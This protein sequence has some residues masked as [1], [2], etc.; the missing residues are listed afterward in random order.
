MPRW[1]EG[2]RRRLIDTSLALFA[3]HGYADASI[4]D[5]ALAAGL[6][7]RTFYRYFTDKE[8]VL[9]GDDDQLLPVLL[10]AIAGGIG[11]VNAERH[12]SAALSRLA[13]VLEPQRETLRI[14]QKIIDSQVSLTGR[15]L[16]KQA[17]W[18]QKVTAALIERGFLPAQADLLAS[19]GFALF[20][21]TLHSW[22]ADDDD[23]SLADRMGEALRHARTVLDVSSS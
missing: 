22:L 16:A 15:E 6:A 13:L 11:P 2:S 19:L 1:P 23:R 8:E 4:R 21:Q 17:L 14:R 3:E 5:I 18:Q 7:P 20:R 10:D 12:M 9:F